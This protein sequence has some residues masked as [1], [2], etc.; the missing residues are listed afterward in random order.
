MRVWA[1]DPY[2]PDGAFDPKG[3]DG[4]F[5]T[6]DDYTLPDN[7]DGGLSDFRAYAQASE[8]T[9]STHHGEEQ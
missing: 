3:P 5:G 1:F 9:G 7:F 4:I 6:E 2:G 8:I